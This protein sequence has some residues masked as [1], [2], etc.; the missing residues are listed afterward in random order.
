MSQ[1]SNNFCPVTSQLRWSLIIGCGC[2]L[3]GFFAA[4]KVDPDPRGFGTH[5]QFGLPPCSFR[6]ILG[7]PC[8]SCGGTTS[9]AH[10]VR[11][12]WIRSIESNVAV[13]CLAAL[14]LMSIPWSLLSLWKGH[15]VGVASLSHLYLTIS[16]S[17]SL[18]AVVQWIWRLV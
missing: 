10:F 6:Q 3:V 5:Q 7:I 18:I 11:G 4:S 8:P 17:L 2:V 16:I 13:F 15:L 9:V 14:G 12:Q 1:T